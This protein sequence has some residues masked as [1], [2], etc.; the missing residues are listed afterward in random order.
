MEL[1]KILLAEDDAGIAEVV[2]LILKDNSFEV[3]V[4]RD[5]REVIK[6]INEVVFSLILLDMSLWGEDGVQISRKIR[7]DSKNTT[8]PIVLLTA[9]ANAKELVDHVYINDIIE[10]PFEISELLNK[11]KKTII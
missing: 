6:L 3:I 10:K 4:P 2:S 9:R 5:Y 7:S 1:K 11:I 8:T